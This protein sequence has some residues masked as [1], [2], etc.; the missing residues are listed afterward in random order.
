MGKVRISK[1]RLGETIENPLSEGYLL[2]NTD[3]F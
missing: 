2:I 3:I 1:V